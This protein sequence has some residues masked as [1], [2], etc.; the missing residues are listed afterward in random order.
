[1]NFYKDKTATTGTVII[2]KNGCS[3]LQGSC[4]TSNEVKRAAA[5]LDKTK[6]GHCSKT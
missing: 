4:E 1:M 6:N 5:S 3:G 2:S